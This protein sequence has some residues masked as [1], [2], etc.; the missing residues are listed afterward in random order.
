MPEQMREHYDM[1]VKR[2]NTGQG[3][4]VRGHAGME[5]RR[6]SS[7]VRKYAQ[8]IESPAAIS[9]WVVLYIIAKKD[10]LQRDVS[11]ILSVDES[12]VSRVRQ[13][14]Q[15]LNMARLLDLAK[16]FDMALPVLIAEATEYCAP[17]IWERHTR[18]KDG[19]RT[20]IVLGRRASLELEIRVLK[21]S[22]ER[23]A[24]E[25][26]SYRTKVPS[27]DT[28]ERRRL[29][30][31]VRLCEE[32]PSSIESLSELVEVLWSAYPRQP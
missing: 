5:K 7:D 32:A 3:S 16:H 28:A 29:R 20:K 10:L 31:M 15:S 22:L 27:S 6:G 26:D 12:F 19:R 21:E 18:S 13:G 2:D 4:E 9:Q 1:A 30:R 17:E 25:I 14:K 23:L 24:T 8:Q 11:E